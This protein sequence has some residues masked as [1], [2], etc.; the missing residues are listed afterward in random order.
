MSLVCRC[1]GK[2]AGIGDAAWD[3][4]AGARTGAVLVAGGDGDDTAAGCVV[5]VTVT[6]F[7]VFTAFTGLTVLGPLVAFAGLAT[8]AYLSA[9]TSAVGAECLR[10]VNVAG[11][12]SSSASIEARGGGGGGCF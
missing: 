10:T 2:R 5:N 8:L 11:S 1:G 6:G 7:V 4:P 12:A 3:V 9:F